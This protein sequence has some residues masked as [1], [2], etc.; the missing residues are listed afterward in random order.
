VKNVVRR[1]SA[2]LA[3]T[4]CACRAFGQVESPL[5]GHYPPGQSGIRGA[6]TPEAGLVYTNF[7]RAFS[8]LELTDAS[9]EPAR[10]LDEVR[11]ANISMFAWTTDHR[12][13]GMRYGALI[14]IPFSTGNLR[15]DAE[16]EKSTDLGLGDVLVTPLALYGKSAIFDYQAQLTLWSA[17]GRFAPGAHDNRGTGFPS[18][19]YSL[20]GVLYPKGDRASWSL[21]AIAR[22]EQN[23]EQDGSDITPG[24]D[25]VLDWGVGKIVRALERPIDLGVSGFAAWQITA[26][27]GGATTPG[28]GRYR[29]FGIGPEASVPL[30]D[31]LSVRIRAHWEFGARNI[32]TG[33]NLWVIFG[34]RV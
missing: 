15:P 34:F 3:L 14:G 30:T 25:V 26:Q 4:A 20:G 21:S 16:E 2:G 24:D 19:V 1:A 9:G 23:F 28:L 17:S 27:T 10:D 12:L 29:I 6:V 11:Y 13:L 33:N 31:R 18:L 32:V 5:T 22:I 7:S 8:N